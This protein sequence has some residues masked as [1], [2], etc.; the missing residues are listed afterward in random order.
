MNK[1]LTENLEEKE[2]R[3]YVFYRSMQVYGRG[4]Q[5]GY[6]RDYKGEIKEQ[7]SIVEKIP[8]CEPK[9]YRKKNLKFQVA[10]QTIRIG[11]GQ[12]K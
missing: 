12:K 10:V 9:T 11:L 4:I 3:N 1:W 5:I 6:G 8:H 2:G 7:L